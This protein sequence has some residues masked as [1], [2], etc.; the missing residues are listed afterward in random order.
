MNETFYIFIG[1]ILYTIA[2]IALGFMLGKYKGEEIGLRNGGV[3]TGKDAERFH[4][5]IDKNNKK[6]GSVDFSKESE[7]NKR[8]LNKS[9]SVLE[10]EIEEGLKEVKQIREGEIPKPSLKEI[11]LNSVSEEEVEKGRSKAYDYKFK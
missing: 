7:S 5:K 2:A 4:K 8:I 10:E 11:K 3:L 9:K 6:Q 1:L